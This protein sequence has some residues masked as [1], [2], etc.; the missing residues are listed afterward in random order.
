MSIIKHGRYNRPP[1]AIALALISMT[2]F[3]MQDV[4][5]KWLASEYWL[6][7]LLFVRSVVIVLAIGLFI[8]AKQGAEG[9]KTS[10]PKN[11][12]LRTV[13]NFFAFLSYYLA[14]TKL[15]LASATSIAMAAPLIMTA[16][17]GPL[18]GEPVGIKRN[19]ILVLGFIG[20]LIIIQPTADDL[21]LSG[22]LYA[23]GGAFLF[24]MLAI[25]SRKMSSSESSE[26]MVF[27]SAVG[28][29]LVT[30]VCMVFYWETPESGALFIMISL[31]GVT[32]FAQYTLVHSYQYARV[33]VI[34]P[35]EYI[36]VLWAVI[37]GWYVFSEAPTSSM[38][39]GASL[40]ILAGL[41]ICWYEKVEYDRNTAP[42]I[43]PV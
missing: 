16:L 35:F 31:G 14:V 13:I 12:I 24:A 38:I 34:A 25:Q 9:F 39:A 29:L 20:V 37:T 30:G 27:Y 33:H 21:N 1:V 22:S 43:N 19:L 15:P 36:T 8:V 41:W 5:V 11:H 23:L 17:A 28:F 2:L 4:L 6:L 40:I 42:P 26:L 10:H 3:S 7:Q 18:L 32:L